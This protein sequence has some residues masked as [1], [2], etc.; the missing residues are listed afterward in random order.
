MVEIA[1]GKIK[2]EFGLDKYATALCGKLEKRVA[3]NGPAIVKGYFD[4]LEEI[5][6]SLRI[7]PENMR[8][9]DSD[10]KI[11]EL[12]ATTKFFPRVFTMSTYDLSGKSYEEAR[13][14]VQ[15]YLGRGQL[16]FL[17]RKLPDPYSHLA[18]EFGKSHNKGW[19]RGHQFEAI[20]RIN[21]PLQGVEE[22]FSTPYVSGM[23]DFDK[24]VVKAN[25]KRNMDPSAGGVKH[26]YIDFNIDLGSY[27]PVSG[28]PLLERLGIS[29][30]LRVEWQ[31]V[32]FYK[33][34]NSSE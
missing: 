30:D 33:G 2:D 17:G 34:R 15:Q 11:V 5:R 23:G 21:D 25:V 29:R 1:S 27:R 20:E 16:T 3:Y 6:Q 7:E 9:G 14:K 31:Q 10:L 19:S 28:Q 8:V 12:L 18:F 24:N 4:M 32:L 22:L 13:E 26:T